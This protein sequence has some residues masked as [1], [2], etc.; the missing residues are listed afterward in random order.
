[1]A[2]RRH[3]RGIILSLCLTGSA[4][5][6]EPPTSVVIGTPPQP[7]WSQLT[8]QQQSILSPL[9]SDWNNLEN[10]RRRK[11]LGIAERYSSMSGEQQARV[12]ERMR[13]WASLTPEQRSKARDTYKG[14]NRLPADQQRLVREKW[15][16]YNNLS[17]DEKLR[18]RENNKSSRLL[19]SPATNSAESATS[20]PPPAAYEKPQPDQRNK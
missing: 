13:E 19:R 20:S 9:A 11:W 14:F 4:F 5:A 17:D 6:A 18:L 3:T 12:Q 10:L 16:A 1:M 15:E 8:P 2:I 7:S